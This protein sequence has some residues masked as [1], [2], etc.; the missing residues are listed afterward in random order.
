[1]DTAVRALFTATRIRRHEGWRQ[2][3]RAHRYMASSSID[4]IAERS[5]DIGMNMFHV[6]E[7]GQ[8]TP[9][10]MTPQAIHWTTLWT[11]I[12]EEISFRGGIPTDVQLFDPSQ[13]D[14]LTAPNAPRGLRVLHG[15]K[16]PTTPYLC[17]IGKAEHLRESYRSG[18]FRISPASSYSD[19][20][21]NRA[22]R[23]DELTVISTSP[24]PEARLHLPNTRERY[25]LGHGQQSTEMRSTLCYP[26][27][28]YLL[29]FSDRYDLRLL[30]DFAGDGLLIIHKPKQF[31][32]RIVQKL[33]KI[34]PHLQAEF[35][36]PL[37]YDPYTIQMNTTRIPMLKH[38]RYAYQHEARVIWLTGG[39]Q[40]PLL[41]FFIEIG[42]LRD[43]ATLFT[44]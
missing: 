11:H 26:S 12:L 32:Q 28:F 43:I 30:D 10:E 40:E 20:N 27:D 41:P 37:Y 1:M 21:H 38:F 6:N 14:R 39:K 7:R 17:K 33:R 44:L 9:G 31:I 35:G 34:H 4:Q 42:P 3:Y 23:D 22:I 2:S 13:F 24:S 15:A 18:R 5:R 16:L 29:C 8:I 19:Q 25:F 36:K